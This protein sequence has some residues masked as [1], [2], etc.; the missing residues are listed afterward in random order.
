MLLKIYLYFY[1]KRD[2][3]SPKSRLTLRPTTEKIDET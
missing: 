1:L 2:F 3:K